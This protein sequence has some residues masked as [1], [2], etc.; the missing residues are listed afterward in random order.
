MAATTNYVPGVCNINPKE[1]AYRR[2]AGYLGLGIFLVV[3]A[4]LIAI[5]APRV[6]RL[7]LILP[8][9]LGASGFLQARNKFCVAYGASGKHNADGNEMVPGQVAEIAARA[10]DAKRAKVINMQSVIYGVAIGL[11]SLLV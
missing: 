11:F 2:K 1:V 8:A 6:V 9:I 3:L 4:I 10:K 7:L 5:D